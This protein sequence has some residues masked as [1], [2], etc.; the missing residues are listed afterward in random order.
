L[1]YHDKMSFSI[2]VLSIIACLH[3]NTFA[4]LQTHAPSR[5]NPVL[6]RAKA[7][8]NNEADGGSGLVPASSGNNKSRLSS[9]FAALDETDQYDAVLTGL[10]A[11]ILDDTSDKEAMAALQDPIKLIQEMNARRVTASGRSLMAIIDA[12]CASQDTT[13]MSEMMSLCLKNGG[14]KKYGKQ[15]KSMTQLPPNP[16]TRVLCSDGTRKTRKERLEGLAKIPTD[17]RGDEVSSALTF[18]AFAGICFLTNFFGMDDIS[19]FTNT[20]IFALTT[21]GILDNFYDVINFGAG[22]ASKEIENVDIKLPEKGSLPLDIGTGKITGTVFRGLIRVTTVDTERESQ[23]EAAAFYAAYVLGLPCYAFRPNALE[24][25]VMV[26]ESTKK[27]SPLD[28]LLSSAGIQKILIWLLAPVAIE[29]SKHAQLVMSDPR[30]SAGLLERIEDKVSLLQN[31]DKDLFWVDGEGE[32]E[33]ED[34]LKWAYAEADK[35][36]RE[37]REVIDEISQ[38]LAGGAATVGDCVAVIEEF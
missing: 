29:S 26:I 27:S 21:F 5:N 14:V 2:Y 33:K 20:L 28:P 24:S 22:V 32:K 6:L 19:P 30:E 35:L 4:L 11:K 38:L 3:A 18:S 23:C 12:T 7:N 16:N 15:Q 36:L 17:D 37:N 13:A 31:K 10:C 34:L 8:K 25:A 1:L 9:A